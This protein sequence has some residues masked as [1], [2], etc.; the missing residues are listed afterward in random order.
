MSSHGLQS[1]VLLLLELTR[2]RIP[3]IELGLDDKVS[4]VGDLLADFGKLRVRDLELAALLEEAFASLQLREREP[5]LAVK[6]APTHV[7]VLL[8]ELGH[9]VQRVGL[10]TRLDLL[11]LR[12]GEHVAQV[13][14]RHLLPIQGDAGRQERQENDGNEETKHVDPPWGS[15]HRHNKKDLG[16]S[17]PVKDALKTISLIVFGVRWDG[18]LLLKLPAAQNADA[19]LNQKQPTPTGLNLML[20]ESTTHM[21]LL[22]KKS[23]I[24]LLT[25]IQ[26][27]GLRIGGQRI[28]HTP[29]NILILLH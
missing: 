16:A 4:V 14:E 9:R 24:T 23:Q 13:L 28:S 12:R 18:L 2:L 6:R 15:G 25:S 8:D 19:K 5:D 3:A 22:R 21:K 27:Y 20:Y 11:L 17:N 10:Q 29:G 1:F 26:Y 7:G